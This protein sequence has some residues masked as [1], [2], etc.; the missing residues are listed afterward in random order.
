MITYL[1]FM[2]CAS[3]ALSYTLTFTNA[4]LNIGR[5]LSESET[6]TGYQD[7]ITPP[8]FAKCA[9]AVYIICAGGLILGF[10]KFGWLAGIGIIIGFLFV[11]AINRAIILP[12]ADGEHFRNIIISSMIKRH[13]D[14][15]KNNDT[16]RASAMA[17]LLEKLKI[18]VN[19]M[20]DQINKK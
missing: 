11:V 13:A 14:Y 2:Y 12:K 17:M 4:T 1:I 10:L 16:L 9:I 5:F 3:L 15:I 19:E 7:A 20:I 8:Q 18:P 6:P